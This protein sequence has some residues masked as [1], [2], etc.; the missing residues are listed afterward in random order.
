MREFCLN[1]LGCGSASPSVRHQPSCQVVNQN[2]KL[3]MID[4]GEGTQ[5]QFNRYRLNFQRLSHI[6]ISHMHGD[7]VLGLPGLLSTFSMQQKNG[8]VTVHVLEDGIEIL[9]RMT[10][11]FCDYSSYEIRYEP[12]PADGGVV[13]ED[14]ALVVKAFPLDHS[15]PCVGFLFE[16]K[17]KPRHLLGDVA[18]QLG[19]PASQ[20]KAI[21][22]GADF[23]TPD[24]HVIEN[25]RLTSDPTPSATYAYCSDTRY[26]PSLAETLRGVDTIYHEATYDDEKMEKA[27]A[28]GHSTA[29]QAA[30]IARDAGAKRL[31]IGHFSKSYVNEDIHRSQAEQYF[32][33]KIIV[34]NE[35]MKINL[36]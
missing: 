18:D 7:H 19:I 11:Y 36:L 24:G 8:P 22:D 32:D 27:N 4:C 9:R 5:L 28:R 10:D 29:G 26:M 16:E 34:A 20:R 35:G 6:F 23:V 17:P 2:D 15:W 1:I 31:I 30:M 3:Y 14:D 13:Y 25:T 21:I 12:I 33:S